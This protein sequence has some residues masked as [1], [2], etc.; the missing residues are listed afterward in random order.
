MPAAGLGRGLYRDGD[1][2]PLPDGHGR[3]GAGSGEIRDFGLWRLVFRPAAGWRYRGGK[4]TDR[5]ATCLLQGS[6]GALHRLWRNRAQYSG[7]EIGAAGY[8]AEA[9]RGRDRRLWPQDERFCGLVRGAGDAGFL[10]SPHGGGDRD[11]GGTGSADAAFLG[12]AVVR[13]GAYGLYRRRC[14]AGD[15]KPSCAHHACSYKGHPS[16]GDRRAGPHARKLP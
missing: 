16:P 6:G 14:D 7:G 1:G 15:R 3:A 10:S 9:D 8:Q 12:A 4:G 2:P 13:C 5:A 11:R